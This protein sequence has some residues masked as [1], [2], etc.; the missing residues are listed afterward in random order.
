MCAAV[1]FL[2]AGCLSICKERKGGLLSICKERK[3]GLLSICKER[4]GGLLSICKER[5]G[6][7]FQKLA[8]A[9][10]HCFGNGKANQFHR[11]EDWRF[12]QD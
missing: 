3:G 4:K 12:L 10:R 6:G 9:I 5:K 2:S 1:E 11:N 7:L 8:V